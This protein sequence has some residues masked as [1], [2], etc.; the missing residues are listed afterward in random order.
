MTYEEKEHLFLMLAG[1]FFLNL[2]MTLFM[3]MGIV[4][5]LVGACRFATCLAE[6][7][8]AQDKHQKEG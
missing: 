3:A 7:K 2:P 6:A 8:K 5:F 4:L 1:L